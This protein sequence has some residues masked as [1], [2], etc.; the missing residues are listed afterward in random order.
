[1]SKFYSFTLPI[2]FLLSFCF[3][4]SCEKGHE[5]LPAEAMQGIALQD[6]LQEGEYWEGN[7][8]EYNDLLF[9]LITRIYFVKKTQT[10]LTQELSRF[11]LGKDNS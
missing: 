10:K 5:D 9:S 7:K 8:L 6:M 3:F 11:G 1:M 2:L 4:T